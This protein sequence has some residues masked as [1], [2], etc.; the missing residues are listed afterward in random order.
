[1]KKQMLSLLLTIFILVS[2]CEVVVTSGAISKSP[3]VQMVDTI[4][5]HEIKTGYIR[6][7]IVRFEPQDRVIIHGGDHIRLH[8]R[9]YQVS[10]GAGIS[11]VNLSMWFSTGTPGPFIADKETH[12]Y[13]RPDCPEVKKIKPGNA[14]TFDIA[15][16]AILAGYY[17]CT[18][19]YAPLKWFKGLSG[20]TTDSNGEVNASMFTPDP[21]S[22]GLPLP[23]NYYYIVVYDGDD[24][25]AASS[26]PLWKI[27]VVAKSP[28]T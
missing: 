26:C 28:S 4:I 23:K 7:A 21:A 24:Y 19:C 10:N 2:V 18:A 12:L 16:E 8:I 3:Q 27:T 11:D 13:H 9:L 5:H 14:I 25:Y 15:E 6:T 17:P 20:G 22:G 1:M